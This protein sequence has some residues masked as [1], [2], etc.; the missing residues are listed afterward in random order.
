MADLNEIKSKVTAKSIRE[1]S[2]KN[3]MFLVLLGLVII[4]GVIKPSFLGWMN[5]RNIM[6]ISSVRIIIAMGAGIILITKGVDL[7][8]GRVV[9]LTACIAASL[10]Q[11]PDYANRMYPGMDP[12]PLLIPIILAVVAGLLVGM[13]NGGVV[14]FF[15]VPPFI[16]TLGT[17][18]I[19]YGVASIYVDRPPLGAQ[20]IGGLREDFTAIGTAAVGNSIFSIPFIVIIAIVVIVG[21]WILLNKT[22]LGKNIYAI[23]GN[24]EAAVVSGVNVKKNLVLV[25]AIAGLLYGLAGTLLSARTGGAT[26]NY[27]LMYELDA[28]AACVIGGVSTSGGIGTVGGI[29][30]GVFIFEVLNNGLVILGV[31]AYWQQ[32]IKGLIIVSAVAL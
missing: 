2:G 21:M 25:Y 6:M 32:I 13:I 20:P 3:A 5:I 10:L 30:I 28:I 1:F 26:N 16:A 9:G 24:T 8:A 17:M 31:S 27:G 11:R 23:G 4:I 15:S 14:S 19:I 7:S 22:E 29:M 18:V 12:L